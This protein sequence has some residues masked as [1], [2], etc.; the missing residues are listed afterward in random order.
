MGNKLI[1]QAILIITSITIVMTYVRPA[2]GEIAEV[3]D[4][5]AR[6][7]STVSKASE[8]NGAL[9]SLVATEQNI[10]PRDQDRLRSYLPRTINNVMVM[11]DIQSIFNVMGLR[12]TALSS[13]SE[14]AIAAP[15]IEG[16][17][18]IVAK[19]QNLLFRDFE[20]SFVGSYE[21]LK[22]VLGAIEAN[23]YALEVVN[24]TFESASNPTQDEINRGLSPGIMQFNL[25]LR[26]YAFSSFSN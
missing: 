1:T 22:R 25:T 5:L 3:Q 11:R 13:A 9:Q 20:L 24:L 14:D 18:P 21:D 6:Y 8:L 2:F 17:E 16:D 26:A 15:M 7:Q 4:D 12:L 10:N 19:N 23:A